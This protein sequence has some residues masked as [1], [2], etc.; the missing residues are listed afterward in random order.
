MRISDLLEGKHRKHFNEL[1]FVKN[2]GEKRELDF[3]LEEDLIHFMHQDD[4]VYRRHTYPAIARCL[5]YKESKR[6]TKKEIFKPAV[7]NSYKIYLEKFPIREL[8]NNLSEELCNQICA[9]IH[10]ET[11]EHISNGKYKD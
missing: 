3:D 4:D 6:P 10:E 5:D 8:P 2:T 7:E 1:D 11:L 9:K